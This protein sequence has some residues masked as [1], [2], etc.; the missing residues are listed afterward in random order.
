V[1]IPG[2]DRLSLRH[3]QIVCV[4]PRL[5]R[6]VRAQPAVGDADSGRDAVPGLVQH[7]E[8]QLPVRLEITALDGPK[9]TFL[10]RGRVDQPERGVPGAVGDERDRAAIGRPA[11]IGVVVVAV[12]ERK[13]VAPVH[14]QQPQLLP[15]ASEITAVDE[16]GAIG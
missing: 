13:R 11:R 7:L 5:V 14:R 16:S 8:I 9:R 15:L 10:P 2:L 4:N 3:D 1:E 6:R 12:G